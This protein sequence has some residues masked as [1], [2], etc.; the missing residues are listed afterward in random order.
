MLMLVLKLNAGSFG[1]CLFLSLM[2]V[3]NV[4]LVLKVSVG[5]FGE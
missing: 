2:L 5:S 4:M 3:L 1:E